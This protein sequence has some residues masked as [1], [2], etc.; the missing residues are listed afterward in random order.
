MRPVPLES[1]AS[2]VGAQ[3][4]PAIPAAELRASVAST[5]RAFAVPVVVETV[6]EDAAHFSP[7]T[8]SWDH[9]E[10]QRGRAPRVAEELS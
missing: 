4:R 5:F 3:G 10:G 1:D 7:A 2:A 8:A 6:S 9:E